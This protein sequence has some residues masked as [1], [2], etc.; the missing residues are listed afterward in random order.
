M[1]IRGAKMG[2]CPP[3]LSRP[4][5]VPVWKLNFHMMF[6]VFYSF[7]FVN[8]PVSQ[9]TERLEIVGLNFD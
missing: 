4:A 7:L 6:T 3:L 1:L 2:V 9:D 5:Y 8:V